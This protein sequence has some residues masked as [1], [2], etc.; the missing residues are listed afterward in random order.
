MW[1]NNSLGPG[2]DKIQMK[3]QDGIN[4]VVGDVERQLNIILQDQILYPFWCAPC[5][6][7]ALYCVMM[8]GQCCVGHHVVCVVPFLLSSSSIHFLFRFDPI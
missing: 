7:P 4:Q 3:L 6:S 1:V 5:S 2:F 8:R